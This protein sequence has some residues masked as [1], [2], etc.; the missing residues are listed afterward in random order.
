[1]EADKL[2]V[3]VV[4]P[5]RDDPLLRQAIASVPLGVELIVAMTAPAT[6]TRL[7]V[8][9]A[10]LCRPDIIAVETSTPGM[11]AGVNLGVR[12]ASNQKIVILDSDCTLEPQ[13]IRAYSVALDETAFV[14]G[15]TFARRCGGW[16]EFAGLGQESLN[17]T[18]ARRARL[19]G[20]SI[21]FLK[22]PFLALGGYDEDSGAS[23]DHEFV[24]RMED[25]GLTTGFAENAVV[26]HQPY[27]FTLDCRAHLG[28]GRSMNYIDCK[29]RGRYGFRICLMRW[30]PSVL[31][32]KLI[33][34]GTASVFR[35]LLLGGMML[36]GYVEARIRRKLGR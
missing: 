20:P 3:S 5:V 9:Q 7:S 29:R 23:C 12:A 17:E 16:S 27:T 19:I 30:Y 18:F 4:I 13:T 26:W 2:P 33:R 21:A 24:L 34:R 8:A 10:K 15:R 31:R 25:A 11:S 6:E 1:M 14:R 22:E 28:Y 32:A 36:L 35:S